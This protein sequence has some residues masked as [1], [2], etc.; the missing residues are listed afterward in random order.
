MPQAQDVRD[1]L[2]G[3]SGSPE[4]RPFRGLLD[5]LVAYDSERNSD[6]VRTLVVFL[7]CSENVS[8]AAE[9]LFLHRNSVPYRLERVRE[10]TG[11][12]YKDERHRLALRLGL[13]ALDDD[14]RGKEDKREDRQE[15]A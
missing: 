8:E 13:L 6:L 4:L 14:I 5:P 9:R 15:D 1:L 12:D 3:L 2:A 11:L 7:D 10:L